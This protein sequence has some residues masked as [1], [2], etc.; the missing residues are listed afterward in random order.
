M[1]PISWQ[2]RKFNRVTK[3]PLASEALALN[4]EADA[5]LLMA[6]ICQEVFGLSVLPKVLCRTDN[7][8]LKEALYSPKV[9]SDRRLRID[10]ARL[11]EMVKEDEI[12][13]EWI[14]KRKQ[15]AGFMTKKVASSV[16]LLEVL[17]TSKH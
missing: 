8:S 1:A 13:V 7:E 4:E 5:G 11:R 16:E 14:E 15:L 6:S 17:S 12:Q 10:I 3:S 2:S 9:V